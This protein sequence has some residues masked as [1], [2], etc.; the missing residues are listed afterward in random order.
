MIFE[1]GEVMK[2][3]LY[4]S[5]ANRSDQRGFALIT[6]LLVLAVL[7]SLLA[8]YMVISKIE[9]A[10]MHASK[11]SATGFFAAEGG[12][13]VRAELI[14]GIFVGYNVP[15]GTAPTSTAPCEGA[16]IG[17]GDLSCIDYTLG[18]RTAQTYVIDHQAGTTPAMIRIPQ[19]ELYQNLNA[20]EY[21]YTA[22]S[23][24]FGPD[25]RTE[26][27]LQLRFKSRLVPLFQFAVFYNKDLEI[28]PGPA[29][30]L[31]GPVHVNGDLYLNSNT[32]LDINGQVSA[33]GSIY[34]GRK[35]G[36]QTPICNS[37]PVR[38]MNPT[39]PLALYP[40]CSS[41]ILI[42][43]NDIQPY[44]GM[45][46]FGV[47]AV[48]VPEPDTLD[49]TPGKLYWDRAD[50]RLVLNLN[51]SNNPVTTTVST[52]IE[53]RN[54]DNSVNVA[55]T[56]TLFACSGSV[57][58]NPAASDNFQAA[59]GTSY[60]FRSNREN[61]NI[62]M[63]DIDL[64]ALLNCLHSSSWFGTGKLLSDSTDGGL[65]FHFT[66]QGSNGTSTA[67]PFVVRVRNGGHI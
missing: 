11:D 40:S 14:R 26:A 38:I 12:L 46:Q 34:R 65:V 16:N 35:D 62:R 44:N 50:L 10:S 51:S 66:A 56:N 21:R 39:S 55:A 32:S 23:E 42:T 18:K 60:T 64:R 33:S 9:L 59:V 52:G 5:A 53:V 58:R 57:R 67:S 28:L 22:N 19:G 43:N 31:N 48:T 6:T 24:A 2:K 45:V 37:V 8:A 4:R 47:Q 27:I 29:M 36:T 63:L 25:E 54:S 49:P 1:N 61:K 41:R 3:L 20:Q 15:S 7:S 17:S 13:N 30:N